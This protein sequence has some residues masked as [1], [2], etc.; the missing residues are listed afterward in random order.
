MVATGSACHCGAALLHGVAFG[1]SDAAAPLPLR[2]NLSVVGNELTPP[3]GALP[4]LPM[5]SLVVIEIIFETHR[6]C[7][8]IINVIF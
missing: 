2:S 1:S 8:R 5:D 7:C 6:A 3:A 4:E